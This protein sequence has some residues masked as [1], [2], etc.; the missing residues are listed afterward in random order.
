[1]KTLRAGF[2]NAFS[3]FFFFCL[4]SAAFPEKRL[5]AQEGILASYHRNF[6]RASLGGKTGILLDAATDERAAEFI[7]YLYEI[8]LQFAL[9]NGPLLRDDPEMISLVVAAARG[10]GTAGNTD[11]TASLWE[12]FAIFEDP[13][14]R[15]EIL[16][17]LGVLGR[18]NAEVVA[19]L[20][21]LLED[22]N[23]A[24]RAGN[25]VNQIVLRACIAALGQLG[26]ESSFPFLFSTMT[27]GY[28]Q[29]IIQETLRALESIQG[30]HTAYLL[31]IIRNNSFPE[32][33]IAFRLGA[34]NERLS[35]AE[36]AEIARTALEV[37]LDAYGA[38]A[39]SLRYDAITVLTRLNWTPA[40]SLA[41]RNFYRVQTDF[42]SG[43]AP[44]ERFLEAIAC[45]AVMES[46]EA[47]QSLTLQ[48]AFINSQ[49]E[50][51]GEYDEDVILAIISALGELGDQV[52]F[53][54]LLYISFLNYPDRIQASAREALNR[55]RW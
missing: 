39:N 10:A 16:G 27:A 36:R 42:L 48:L 26:D 7:G 23:R 28:P 9:A 52:A 50:R 25:N 4:L 40:A 38:T 45:L 41:L 13:H 29:V 35:V 55:L 33:T 49:T 37:S 21:R 12:L 46:T 3:C 51:T 54:H 30:N 19:N 44:R 32:K 6:M 17:A 15:A 20:N 8:A 5:A 22:K 1:M 14:P 53:D 31:N 24:F 47:A 34:Y 2:V 43:A 11:S 18:G